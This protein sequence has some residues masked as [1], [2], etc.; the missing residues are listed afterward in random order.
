VHKIDRVL[1]DA[2]SVVARLGRL[3]L[4]RA[5]VRVLLAQEGENGVA[6]ASSFFPLVLLRRLFG[7]D[8]KAVVDRKRVDVLNQV[9]L[10]RE[11][12]TQQTYLA[13]GLDL[14]RPGR[15]HFEF[16]CLMMMRPAPDPPGLINH[17]NTC[18]L[19]AILQALSHTPSF[20]LTLPSPLAQDST[21]TLT[22][23]ASLLLKK[24]HEDEHGGHRSLSP[25]PL[26]S[27][28]ALT[29]P[30]FSQTPAPH[31]Q[32]AHEFLR[33]FCDELDR[34]T[35]AVGVLDTPTT[36]FM[37]SLHSVLSCQHCNT[38]LASKID[39]FLDLS[40]TLPQQKAVRV[41]RG[42]PA[43][44]RLHACLS[45]FTRCEALATSQ[46][47]CQVCHANNPPVLKQLKVHALPQTLVVHFKRFN[48][49][50]AVF[51]SPVLCIK[52]RRYVQFPLRGLCLDEFL[53]DTCEQR[54]ALYDLSCVV[55]HHGKRID[56]GHYTCYCLN[57][58]E[59]RWYH[60]DDEHVTQVRD[61]VVARCEAYLLFYS[62][63]G[64]SAKE[65]KA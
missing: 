16:F 55:V 63:R 3:H 48:W 42:Q 4:V 45:H 49:T 30:R 1:R 57:V 7:L 38:V 13:R 6:A 53:S 24:Q 50:S 18:F 19:N 52:A 35:R 41:V 26:L 27:S 54:N 11:L 47:V 10:L 25:L 51:P 64:G 12:H 15:R 36:P 43:P 21:P 44:L 14:L 46:T 28:L 17:G 32:D 62:K 56:H 23:L 58:P 22:S 20:V 33:L 59:N 5:A 8:F 2:P 31:Q 37:G 65:L 61:E 9:A 39:P 40:L 29:L 60:F 34:Q